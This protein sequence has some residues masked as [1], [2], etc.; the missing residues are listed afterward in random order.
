M[1]LT[2][3][4]GKWKPEGAEAY[5]KGSAVLFEG[6]RGRLLADYGSRTLF[7][8]PGLT[9]ETPPETIS[10]S[11]GHHQE[12]IRA[13][14]TCEATTCNFDYSGVL[15]EAVLLGNVSYRTGGKKLDWD[16]ELL[17]PPTAPRPTITSAEYRPGWTL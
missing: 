4:H 12:W 2:W 9:A 14:K 17:K 3:Y 8:E 16:D 13:G 1:H 7:L 10:R 5:G 15:A 6:E 11:I